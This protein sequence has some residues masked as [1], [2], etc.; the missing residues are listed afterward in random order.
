[1]SEMMCIRK[2]IHWLPCC[3]Q[4]CTSIEYCLDAIVAYSTM[5][6]T[7]TTTKGIHTGEQTTTEDKEC[8]HPF[9]SQ[10]GG[11]IF[12]SQ[13]SEEICPVCIEE[14]EGEGDGGIGAEG[15]GT[16]DGHQDVEEA[17]VLAALSWQSFFDRCG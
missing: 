5:A 13:A 16:D 8:L 11:P 4:C 1:M 12:C 7:T 10:S 2:I 15:D 6:T 9:D 14:E 3:H 17:E